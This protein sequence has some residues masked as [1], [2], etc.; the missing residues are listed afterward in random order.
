MDQDRYYALLKLRTTQ[1]I[2]T[3]CMNATYLCDNPSK[4]YGTSSTYAPN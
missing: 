2:L 3:I 4:C 1:C